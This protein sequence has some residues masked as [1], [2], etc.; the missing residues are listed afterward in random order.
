MDT[1][2]VKARTALMDT[3]TRLGENFPPVNWAW[4]RKKRAVPNNITTMPS[5]MKEA[6]K[7]LPLQ[8]VR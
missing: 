2:R 4:T 8:C 5:A 6:P 7:G 3:S 1:R